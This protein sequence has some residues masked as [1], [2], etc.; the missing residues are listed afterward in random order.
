[1]KKI[2]SILLCLCAV[3]AV[4]AQVIKKGDA[5]WNGKVLY[6]VSEIRMGKIVCMQGVDAS[7]NFYE[8]TLEKVGKK[9]GNY[10]LIPSRQ[11]D[12]SP[13]RCPWNSRVTYVRKNGMYFLAVHN[14]AAN[15]IVETLV[16]TPDNIT[17]CQSQFEDVK[18]RP[19]SSIASTYLF[20]EELTTFLFTEEMK[21]YVKKFASKKNRTVIEDTNLQLMK[22]E[23]EERE[24][25]CD[26]NGF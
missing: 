16:L 19:I 12:D 26:D 2:L 21:K 25:S 13:F 18:E 22:S 7:G 17:N 4:Q 24:S 20:N 14:A 11:A 6:T 9:A 1:M 10:K 3:M 8:L 15:L 23:L 5:F